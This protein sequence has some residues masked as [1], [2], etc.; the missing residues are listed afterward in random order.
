MEQAASF[1]SVATLTRTSLSIEVP[2]PRQIDAEVVSSAYF[3]LLRVGAVAGRLFRPEEDQ[4][5]GAHPVV[6]L[7][8]RLWRAALGA[9]PAVVG[10]TLAVNGVTARR[11]SA[12]CRRVCR[13]QRPSRPLAS[14]RDGAEV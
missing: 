2:G 5:P 6:L 1:E 14:D 10:R 3:D 8:A 7:S 12:F 11:S 4:L 9:D 13:S